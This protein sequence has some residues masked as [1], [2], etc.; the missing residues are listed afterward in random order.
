MD[1]QASLTGQFEDKCRNCG[2]LG[3]KAFECNKQ[4]NQID[5][6]NSNTSA[7]PYCTYCHKTGHLQKSFF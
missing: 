4:S 2:K 5:E 6:N 3:R 7:T 1:E